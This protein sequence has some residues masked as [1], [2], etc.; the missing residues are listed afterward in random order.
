MGAC[1]QCD[2]EA[3]ASPKA[4]PAAEADRVAALG[5]DVDDDMLWLRDL[6]LPLAGPTSL[7]DRSRQAPLP[8]AAS[9][10]D[11]PGPAL[12]HWDALAR[13]EEEGGLTATATPPREQV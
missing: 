11:T 1:P 6:Y 12:K 5:L 8:S 10:A 7:P 3:H 2:A 9:R 4:P 13:W